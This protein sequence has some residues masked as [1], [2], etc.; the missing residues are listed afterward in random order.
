MKRARIL[1]KTPGDGPVEYVL[2]GPEVFY[3]EIYGSREI[4]EVL[5]VLIKG[6]EKEWKS[7]A[8]FGVNLSS[9]I[10]YSI[11]SVRENKVVSSGAYIHI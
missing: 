11:F 6:Q 8:K 4:G 9:Y 1:H 10:A 7:S 3:P 5:G 2:L